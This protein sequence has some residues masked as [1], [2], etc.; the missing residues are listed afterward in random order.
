MPA[1][2]VMDLTVSSPP[3][4]P[5]V[6]P[7]NADHGGD[8]TGQA[9]HHQQLHSSSSRPLVSPTLQGVVRKRGPERPNHRLGITALPGRGKA[10][11]QTSIHVQR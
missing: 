3:Q 10:Q 9:R 6:V 1:V 8:T 11:A 5:T 4:N 7:S 2:I